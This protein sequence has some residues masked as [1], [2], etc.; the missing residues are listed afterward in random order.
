MKKKVKIALQTVMILQGVLW[1]V[2]GMAGLTKAD[3]GMTAA[4]FVILMLAN[5]ILFI[6]LALVVEKDMLIL[7]IFTA[8]FIFV[9]LI[10]TITDQVGLFDYCVLIL[11]I[12]SISGCLYLYLSAE[13]Q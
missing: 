10:L 7:K 5:G 3:I 12:M 11:N 8:I 6:V 2:F 1:I 9:N 4:L 13:K